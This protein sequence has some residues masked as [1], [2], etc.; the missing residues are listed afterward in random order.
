MTRIPRC[1][2]LD[3]YSLSIIICCLYQPKFVHQEFWGMLCPHRQFRRALH[4][5]KIRWAHRHNFVGLIDIIDLTWSL[6]NRPPKHSIVATTGMIRALETRYCKGGMTSFIEFQNASLHLSIYNCAYLSFRQSA[7]N[8]VVGGR[9][10]SSTGGLVV[11][12]ALENLSFT[13]VW[14]NCVKFQ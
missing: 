12:R 10:N 11:I 7:I 9:I 5:C 13:S 2:N 4:M 8:A 14:L 1:A 6:I 3:D